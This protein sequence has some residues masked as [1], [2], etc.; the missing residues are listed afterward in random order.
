MKEIT[1]R[2]RI[3]DYL[4]MHGLGE[5]FAGELQKHLMLVSFA[6]GEHIC[7]KGDPSE[8]LYVLVKGKLKVY[9]TSAEGKTLIIGFKSPLELIGDIEYIQCTEMLNTVEAVSP[10]LMLAINYRLL[11]QYGQDHLPLLQFLLKVI[12]EKFYRKSHFLSLNLM[13]PVEVRLAS[14]LLSI[15]YDESSPEFTGRL[16]TISLTDTANFIG[17]SYRHLNRVIQKLAAQGLIERSKGFILVKDREGLGRLAGRNIY[18]E[19]NG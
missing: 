19:W 2:E 5:I 4:R 11:R 7:I 18:E 12:T 8:K 6:A 14:Y 3:A 13:H 9:T 15:T 1:D 16:S 17:T 10:V